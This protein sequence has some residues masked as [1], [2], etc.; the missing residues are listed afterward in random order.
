M[1]PRWSH[2]DDLLGALMADMLVTQCAAG[3]WKNLAGTQCVQS[4]STWV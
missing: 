1:V 3:Y 2:A 4:V